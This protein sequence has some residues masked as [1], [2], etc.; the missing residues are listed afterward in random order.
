VRVSGAEGLSLVDDVGWVATGNN[1]NQ[2][3]RI[4]EAC[5]RVS[6]DWAER[7]ELQFDTAKTEAALF[8]RRRGHK[9]HLRPKL[10]AKIRVGNGFVRFYREATRWLGVWMDAHLTFKEHQ[11]RCMK[12]ARATEARLRSLT[13]AHGVILACVRAV[14]VA[15]VQ[16]VALYGSELLWDPK[17]GSWRDDLQLLFNRQ[18]RSTLRA[19]LTTLS[20]TLMRDAGLTQA[21]VALDARLQRFVL[22]LANLCEGSKAKELYDYPTPGAPVG[23][24]AETEHTRGRTAE[25]MCWPDP[26]E[27]P[28][29]KTIVLEDDAAAKRAA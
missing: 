23:R 26:G 17:E 3:V 18:A 19:L 16:T 12:K 8:T 27:K 15:C 28:A 22:R 20:G 29:V 6:I 21:A 5:A 14:Q 13:G 4:L 7:W 25:T 10:P 9:K 11:S 2:V 24:L 1:V